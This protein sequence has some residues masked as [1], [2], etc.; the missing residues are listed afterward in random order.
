M[1]KLDWY[2]IKKF[3]FTFFYC[4]VLFTVIAIAVDSSEK[5]DDFVKTGFTTYQIITKYYAGFIPWIWGLL[6]P[7]FVFIAVIFF[8]SRM[9]VRSEIIAILASGTS[10]NRFLR[11]FFL[12][13]LIL[14][15]ILFVANRNIIPKGNVKRTD[16]QTMYVDAQSYYT[17]R[18]YKS[19]FYRRADLNTYVG[20]RDYD[21]SSKMAT[22]FFME[23][24]G[25]DK[26]KEN[27]RADVI[28]WDTARKL[29]KLQNVVTRKFDSLQENITHSDS[30]NINLNISPD[31][32][33]RDYYLK[34]KLTSSEL[35]RFIK[36]EELRGSEGLN[37]YKVELYRRSAT[38]AAVLLLTIIGAVIAS[39]KTRGGSGLHLAL[40]F[41]I[42]AVF[43]LSDRF[44]TVFSTNAD[45]P[46]LIA[47]W[48]PN[49]LF[50][51]IAYWLYRKA[52][53]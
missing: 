51:G 43:V 12:G 11:P 22:G 4:L 45:L 23:V 34:D 16:F 14:A 3:L 46:P 7:I 36:M 21:T 9:A 53:K 19:T 40:G 30:L 2:I 52:P 44:S 37:T 28:R 5:T 15:T 8:T 27:V 20:I 24:T 1:T 33:K 38:P 32:L 31:D 6:F 18:D 41:I 49:L 47:A 17:N 48:L 29:W 26:V 39:R 42:A 25:K 35:K 10:Y 50:A 13:G